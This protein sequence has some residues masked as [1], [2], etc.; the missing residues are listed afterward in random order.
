MINFR[1][2]IADIRLI[3][4]AS[5]VNPST[6]ETPQIYA[7]TGGMTGLLGG[8]ILFKADRTAARKAK[9]DPVAIYSFMACQMATAGSARRIPCGTGLLAALQ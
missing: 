8:A 1:Y 4:A 3:R 9:C 7:G 5:K 2:E 6:Q